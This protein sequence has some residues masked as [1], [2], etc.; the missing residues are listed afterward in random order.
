L[1]QEREEIRKKLKRAMEENLK[2]KVEH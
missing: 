2:I 1:E